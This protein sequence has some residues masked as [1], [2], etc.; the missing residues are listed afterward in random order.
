[1]TI[2]GAIKRNALKPRVESFAIL[3]RPKRAD[4]VPDLVLAVLSHR[5]DPMGRVGSIGVRHGPCLS[6][7]R[8]PQ[9][10]ASIAGPGRGGKVGT[11]QASRRLPK[12]EELHVAL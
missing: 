5:I 2:F 12:G 1:M 11:S 9:M 3:V 6:I 7:A 10:A 4:R 8:Q